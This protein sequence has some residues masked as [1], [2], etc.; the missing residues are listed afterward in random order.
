M[1]EAVDQQP[2]ADEQNKGDGDFADDQETANAIA[3]GP[4]GRIPATFLQGV[5]D[6]E[7]GR[8]RRGGQTEDEPG[9]E[10]NENREDKHLCIDVDRLGLR[11]IFR[12]KGFEDVDPDKRQDQP[13]ATA[14]GREQDALSQ[15][16]SR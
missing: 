9:H 3:A 2:G 5:V 4:G 13:H 15:E 1:E 7:I 12:N 14:Q 10:R 8:L 6:I 11:N 16:L